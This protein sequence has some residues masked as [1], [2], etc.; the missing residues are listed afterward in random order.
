MSWK[1]S[2]SMVAM[3]TQ[4]P[5]VVGVVTWT[6]RGICR[7]PV[8]RPARCTRWRA[9]RGPRLPRVTSMYAP[10]GNTPSASWPL[11]THIHPWQELLHA[12]HGHLKSA[13][14]EPAYKNFPFTRN[15]FSFSNLKQGTSLLYFYEELWL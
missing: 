1:Q 6:G 12:N 10:P 8:R 15:W 11:E 2:S 9:C 5:C 14:K 7:R 3:D 4:L 13:Y